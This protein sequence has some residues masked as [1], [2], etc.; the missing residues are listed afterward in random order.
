L[1]RFQDIIADSPMATRTN[2]HGLRLMY[3]WTGP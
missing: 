3:V 1:H 2:E